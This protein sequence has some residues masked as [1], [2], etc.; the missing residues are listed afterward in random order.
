MAKIVGGGGGG[1]ADIAE[2]GGKDAQRLDEALQLGRDLVARA[3]G[4]AR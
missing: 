3:S 2:A 1:R 4:V